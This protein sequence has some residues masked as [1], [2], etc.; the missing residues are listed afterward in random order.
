MG[1][2]RSAHTIIHKYLKLKFLIDVECAIGSKRYPSSAVDTSGNPVI[3]EKIKSFLQ[4]PGVYSW[5]V[6]LV[7][8]WGLVK[9]G[10]KNYLT[11]CYQPFALTFYYG[12]DVEGL[13]Q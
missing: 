8:F 12:E 2:I 13:C 7:Q 4:F 5:Q 9:N 6:Y 1:F 10:D 11:T 3:K